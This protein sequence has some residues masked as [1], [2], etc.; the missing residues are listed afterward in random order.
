MGRDLGNRRRPDVDRFEVVETFARA[1]KCALCSPAKSTLPRPT[2]CGGNS[3][4]GASRATLDR[5][6]EALARGANLDVHADRLVF[7]DTTVLFVH[8]AAGALAA[9]AARMPGAITEIRRA[10]GTI[11]PFLDR[12]ENGLGQHD[13]VAELAARV[14][15]PAEDAPAVCTLDTGVSAAHPLIAPG[16]RGAWAYDAAWGTDDHHAGRRSRNA[17]GRS[18][19]LRR[20]GAADERCAAGGAHPCRRVDEAAPAKWLPAH[21]AAELRRRYSGRGRLVEAERPN[22]RRSFCMATSATDFPPSRPSSWSGAL[23]QIAAG[24]M[25]GD[26]VDGVPASE[27]PKRL[28][29]VATGNVSGGMMVD[30]CPRSR[31]KIPRRV[32]TP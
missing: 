4:F 29:L 21:E 19:P 31:S 30:V 1:S 22:V 16:L 13:W 27:R 14:T 20:S 32:G 24:S 3:G 9:F 11:E 18:C 10:T 12:G 25:P 15:P 23:D 2:S 17:A 26:A 6:A 5:L 28:V 7:P 8:A